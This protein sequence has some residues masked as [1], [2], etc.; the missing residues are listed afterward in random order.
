IFDGILN[1]EPVAP[2][3]LNP[4]LPPKLEEIINRALEK[5]RN[6]R[7]QHASDLHAEFQRLRRDSSS[8]RTR[9]LL[10]GQTEHVDLEALPAPSKVTATDRRRRG[11]YV[12][13]AFLVLAG[14][15][16][17]ILL[18]RSSRSSPPVS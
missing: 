7:F 17:A 1:R 13:A 2:V 14:G 9:I 8:G 16:G 11:Y 3:R 15:V 4:D 18:Y 12:T 5:D 10:S 6:L